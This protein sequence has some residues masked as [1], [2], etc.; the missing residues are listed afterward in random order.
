MGTLSNALARHGERKRGDP[1]ICTFITVFIGGGFSLVVA[2]LPAR[3]RLLPVAKRDELS[4]TGVF[5][6]IMTGPAQ[7]IQE[8][9][10]CLRRRVSRRI[11]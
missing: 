11:H 2:V 1:T 3:R 10:D 8:K 5:H 9:N 7:H 6:R 4:L